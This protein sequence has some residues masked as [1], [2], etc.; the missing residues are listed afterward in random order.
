MIH[1]KRIL[2]TSIGLAFLFIQ[3]ASAPVTSD[4]LSLYYSPIFPITK[5]SNNGIANAPDLLCKERFIQPVGFNPILKEWS[6]E[7]IPTQ[8]KEAELVVKPFNNEIRQAS[9]RYKI[10]LALLHAVIEVESGYRPNA[11]SPRGAMGLMQLMPETAAQY[12]LKDPFDPDTNIDAGARHLR[13]LIDKYGIERG[14]AAY[15]AGEG[16]VHKFNGV[17]PYPETRNYVSRILKLIRTT[18]QKNKSIKNNS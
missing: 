14:L 12:S 7:I 10:D 16:S 8:L 9:E 6:A 11:E 2:L 4:F 1:F 13:K 17:P 3:S 15:N 5:N 18:Q